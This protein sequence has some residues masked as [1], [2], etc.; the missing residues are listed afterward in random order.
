MILSCAIGINT[1]QLH[2]WEVGVCYA[3]C[4]FLTAPKQL[5]FPRK[6]PGMPQGGESSHLM[7][8]LIRII[9]AVRT[10][11]CFRTALLLHQM[12]G[13]KHLLR[14]IR[15]DYILSTNT[16]LGEK[17]WKSQYVQRKT[18]VMNPCAVLRKFNRS[19]VGTQK[20]QEWQWV[21]CGKRRFRSVVSHI[22]VAYP[23]HEVLTILV[24][25]SIP[26]LQSS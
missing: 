1:Q 4:A 9:T 19:K 18:L 16:F 10:G 12:A 21:W 15:P 8:A 7:V 6:H 24:E 20:R 13:L 2:T 17:A 3:A 5:T 25:V 26:L 22:L 23:N 11:K 14:T